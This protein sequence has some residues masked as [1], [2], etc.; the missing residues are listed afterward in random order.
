MLSGLVL[1]PTQERLHLW[2]ESLHLLE[3]LRASQ[4]MPDA[5]AVT[6]AAWL[7]LQVA[8]PNSSSA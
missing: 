7:Q 3:L 4:K 1:G 6:T 8:T 2:T 5:V